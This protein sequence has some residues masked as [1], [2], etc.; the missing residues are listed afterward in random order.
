MD[1]LTNA[2]ST[3]KLDSE[4]AYELRIAARQ[5]FANRRAKLIENWLFAL[6]VNGCTKDL[7]FWTKRIEQIND[8]E[9]QYMGGVY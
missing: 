2:T 7:G 6:D 9:I 1:T 8:A 4:D 5:A 3:L